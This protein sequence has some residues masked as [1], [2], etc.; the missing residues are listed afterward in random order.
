MVCSCGVLFWLI[1]G[2]LFVKFF[3]AIH[4]EG[5]DYVNGVT[6]GD[7]TQR[8]SYFPIAVNFN[9]IF[10]HKVNCVK[11]MFCGEYFGH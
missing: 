4:V 6:R 10:V 9:V 2:S 1:I 7:R 5:L 8:R 3:I 11:C